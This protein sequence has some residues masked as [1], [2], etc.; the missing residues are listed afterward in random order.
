MPE[1]VNH[2]KL[3]VVPSYNEKQHLLDAIDEARIFL[4]EELADIDAIPNRTHQLICIFSLIDCLAQEQAN[5]PDNFKSAFCQFVLKH[6]KQCDYLEAIEPITLF[7]RVE[8]D[9]DT[10]VKCPNAPPEKEVTL[11]ELGCLYG[12]RVKTLLDTGKADEIISYIKKKHGDDK[13]TRL[14]REHQLIYLLYR[15]RNKAVH[16][17]SGLG[18]VWNKENKRLKLSEPFYRAVGRHYVENGE[19][20]SYNAI[21]LVIPNIFVRNIL[22]D[23]IEGY[24]KDCKTMKRL[25]FSNNDWLTRKMTLSWYDK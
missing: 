10:V 4:Q 11:D 7:Y 18:E 15:M 16:E 2:G 13:A 1:K 8:E 21:E 17:M 9:I 24:L 14:A 22:A 6:Q 19:L 25:P 20:V 23:C 12:E 3:E 5:Y